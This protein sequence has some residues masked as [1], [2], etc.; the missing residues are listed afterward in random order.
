MSRTG[1][2]GLEVSKGFVAKVLMLLIG[3]AGSIV[4][5]RVLGPAGY[6]AFHVV[7]AA[8][9]ILDNPVSG[10][11]RACKKRISEHDRDAGEILSVG[12]GATA[13]LGAS[14]GSLLL[15]V[16]PYVDYFEIE[17]G[18]LFLAITFLG[19]IFF[20][21]VQP[22]V[23][24]RGQFGTAVFLDSLRSF[25]TIPLQIVFV[26][27]LGLGVA[28]MVWGLVVAT[29]LT[30]P[31]ALYTLN[32]RPTVPDMETVVSVWKYAKFS[33]PSNFIGTA[34]SKIDILLLAAVLGAGASGQYKIAMQLVLPG[35][36]I[37]M[38]MGS[39]LFA[40]VSTL[41]SQGE[42][43][44]QRV[45]NNI[46][47]A[48]FF[49][50]PL[51]FGALA[52]PEAIVVTVFGKEYSE[53]AWLLVGLAVYQIV[54][55]QSTQVTSVVEGMDRPDIRLYI[56]ALTLAVN[57]VLGVVLVY[58]IGAKGIVVATIVAEFIK[59]SS[60]TYFAKQHVNYEIIPSP[61]RW[62]FVSAA[63]M[64]VVVELLHRTWG[65]RSWFELLFIVGVGA[66]VYALLLVS[67]SDV[68]M[69]TAKSIL[70]DARKQ[71]R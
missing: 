42:D 64:F 54:A 35:A 62:Q 19:L 48:S 58:R 51:F 9:N 26:V 71:Y 18:S 59:F 44:S 7:V 21:I 53:A 32:V 13:I 38:V 36:M 27:F 46:A 16:G 30:V 22:M 2:F 66:V 63:V 60:M 67:L 37:S 15:I 52:M 49:A 39:G 47:F 5:A 4:F 14:I 33:I 11:G 29:L 57:I 61:M 41:A 17:N 20:K 23:A 70:A 6:G 10:L 68:F 56:V 24:G 43:V 8:A 55:T 65:V 31:I 69:H 1:S 45:T 28:G 25:F 3:F 40:E 50:I 12:L 34:Y